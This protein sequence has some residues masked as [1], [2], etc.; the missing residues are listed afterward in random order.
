MKTTIIIKTRGEG[1]IS[2]VRGQFGGGHTGARCGLS[3][4]EAAV[5]AAELMLRYGRPNPEGAI[6]MAPQEVMD[7]VPPHL[8]SIDGQE[9]D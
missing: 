4:Y 5:S 1:Y 8:R 7:L 9:G 6:L 2:T 3:P